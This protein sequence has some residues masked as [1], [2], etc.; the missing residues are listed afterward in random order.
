[1]KMPLHLDPH[2]GQ[3]SEPLSTALL[4]GEAYWKTVLSSSLLHGV[5]CATPCLACSA[6]AGLPRPPGPPG[7]P[8]PRLTT[9]LRIPAPWPPG[10]GSVRGVA[11]AAPPTPA[12]AA[13][14]RAAPVQCTVAAGV[15][16]A[17]GA[18]RSAPAGGGGNSPVGGRPL[19]QRR[20]WKS[21]P[22]AGAG[23]AGGELGSKRPPGWCEGLGWRSEGPGGLRSSQGARCAGSGVVRKCGE[24]GQ[25]AGFPLWKVCGCCRRP[26]RALP[27]PGREGGGR[28]SGW[29][30]AAGAR[31]PGRARSRRAGGRGS[32]L[33][34]GVTRCSPSV[35]SAEVSSHRR[36]SRPWGGCSMPARAA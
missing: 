36:R 2:Q 6:P 24:A 26:G 35:G 12:P 13:V 4:E 18:V 17:A 25:G 11:G 33:P 27:Q 15:A 28:D 16:G 29:E 10:K 8:P 21:G 19:G 20:P 7:G 3:P 32:P 23:A 5:E 14:H 22:R 30:E 31:Q 9:P 34:S 1:M